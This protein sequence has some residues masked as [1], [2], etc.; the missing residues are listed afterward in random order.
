MADDALLIPKEHYVT[1]NDK[2]YRVYP[3]K[4]KDYH[5]VDRLF[6]KIND[7]YLFLNLPAAM[8]DKDGKPLLD[9]KGN[10]KIDYNAFNAMLDLFELALHIPRKE[11]MEI[12]D[13]ESGVE[14]L[15]VFRGI[16]GL[17]K[18]MMEQ[19]AKIKNPILG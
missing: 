16:S 9:A 17:K 2:E 19:L 15:D 7:Q 1:L 10:P 14:V 8:T 5:R 4:L 3:M 12:I 13:L 11:I 18:K 6:S